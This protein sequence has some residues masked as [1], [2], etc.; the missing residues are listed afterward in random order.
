MDRPSNPD[1]AKVETS[2]RV[3]RIVEL[4]DRLESDIRAKGLKPGDPYLSTLAASQM[5]GVGGGPANRAMQLLE[6]RQVLV[7]RQRS[8]AY[9]AQPPH[10]TPPAEI[11]RVHLLVHEK[12][13]KTEGVGADGMLVGMQG[14]LPR[15]TVSI[16]FLPADNGSRFVEDLILQALRS[17]EPDG[18]V[19]VRASFE[20]QQAIAASGL[21]AVVHGTLYPSINGLS[22]VERDQK[23]MIR[24]LAHY[25]LERGRRRVAFLGRQLVGPGDHVSLDTLH[26]VF[27]GDALVVRHLPSADAAITG[28]ARLLF[29]HE[30][31]PTGFICQTERLAD[32][33]ARAARELGM[34]PQRDVDITVCCYYLK[35]GE[36]GRYPYARLTLSPE[37]IGRHIGRLLSRQARGEQRQPEHELIPVALEVP[38]SDGE[39]NGKEF[40]A[41]L[42][43][44]PD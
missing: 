12:Y 25:L 20:T 23:A 28:E 14:E 19:L 13:L 11:R 18:F 1:V 22:Y 17:S 21:P 27:G 36:T 8:G 3:A 40:D 42:K 16:N 44:T 26:Q 2:H 5:L 33:V 15:A 31:R 32:G 30:C 7:R 38:G 43:N 29:G 24:V 34:E 9:I 39:G 41:D 37:E 6:K 4:A 35:A 10:D